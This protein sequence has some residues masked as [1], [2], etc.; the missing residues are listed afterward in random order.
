MRRNLDGCAALAST[1]AQDARTVPEGL[2]TLHG[3]SVPVNAP[4]AQV[5]RGTRRG[6][7]RCYPQ[8]VSVKSERT[9]SGR[10]CLVRLSTNPLD[11]DPERVSGGQVFVSC[12]SRA[13]RVTINAGASRRTKR[14][15]RHPGLYLAVSPGMTRPTN[16]NDISTSRSGWISKRCRWAC[17]SWGNGR[18]N[19]TKRGNT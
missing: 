18:T 10:V 8:F 3:L 17:I 1:W 7:S 13:E 19:Y 11:L 14:Q 4:W 6:S 15:A 16:G 12:R 5:F 2:L 9:R